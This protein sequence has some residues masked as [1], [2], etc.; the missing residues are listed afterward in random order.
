MNKITDSLL[1]V[2]ISSS[3]SDREAFTDRV[4]QL[5]EQHST[6]SSDAAERISQGIASAMENLNEAILIEQL[7]KPDAKESDRV[8]TAESLDNLQ[9]ALDKLN[10]NIEQLN[11]N[12]EKLNVHIEKLQ[13]Q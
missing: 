5:I 11:D 3:L 4:A 13:P 7:L 2:A 1:R 9:L 6:T 8:L 10:T 12:I